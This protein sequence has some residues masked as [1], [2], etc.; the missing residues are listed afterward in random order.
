[1]LPSKR[2]E[3]TVSILGKLRNKGVPA[4]AGGPGQA[5]QPEDSAAGTLE[6]MSYEEVNSLGSA[7]QPSTSLL[8]EKK[9]QK[10]KPQMPAPSS[11]EEAY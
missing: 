10:R 4:G 3:H 5:L 6:E 11:S 7:L 9:R 1:M 8:P 2:N